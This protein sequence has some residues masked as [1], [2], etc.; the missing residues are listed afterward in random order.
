VLRHA[1]HGQRSIGKPSRRRFSTTS[2]S[3]SFSCRKVHDWVSRWMTMMWDN[4]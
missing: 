1:T 2:F 4:S 3:G